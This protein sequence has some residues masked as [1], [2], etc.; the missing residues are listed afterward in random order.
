MNKDCDTCKYGKLQLS[1]NPCSSCSGREDER[2]NWYPKEEEKVNKNYVKEFMDDNGLK[3]GQ[4]F[5]IKGLPSCYKSKGYYFDEN[6][7]LF[8]KNCPKLRTNQLIDR[9]IDLLKGK[10]QV[11]FKP[12][13]PQNLPTEGAR[14]WIVKRFMCDSYVFD[15]SCFWMFSLV[16]SGNAFRTEAE[17]EENAPRIRKEQGMTK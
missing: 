3:I 1:E 9:L 10:L 8:L 4:E 13:S 5:S 14:F 15:N 17:A 2:T 16:A 11:E 12:F 7:D 6:Y